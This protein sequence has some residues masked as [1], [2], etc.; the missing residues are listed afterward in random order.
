M[1]EKGLVDSAREGLELG[2]RYGGPRRGLGSIQDLRHTIFKWS[3]ESEIVLGTGLPTDGPDGVSDGVRRYGDTGV[4]QCL[5]APV[6][7]QIMAAG[8]R[9]KHEG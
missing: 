3:I 7:A 9:F 4:R 5:Y 2:V 6:H 8:T 1:D